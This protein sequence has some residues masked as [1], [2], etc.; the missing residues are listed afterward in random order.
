MERRDLLRALGSAT[1]L[2]FLPHKTLEAWTRVAS[3]ILPANGLDA[4]QMAL[5]RAVADTI[6]PRTE[7]PSA[8]DVGV[9]G[10]VNV[11]VAE[12]ATDE[13]RAEFL[14]GLA[15]ID[16]K[17][18]GSGGVV[19]ADLAPEARGAL[20]DSLET[21]NRDVE[22]SRTYWRLKGLIVH[23]YFT[24]EPVMKDVLK[25]TVMPGKFEGDAPLLM[26]SPRA[27]KQAPR[28]AAKQPEHDHA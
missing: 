25:H 6:L 19:F 18:K 4:A 26:I 24:S 28:P 23:G 21:G 9:H 5:V 16:E 3:G 20:L 1:A 10:F 8:T 27:P 12:Q 22:P 17:A 14:R 2:T 13:E 11:M 15:A 7:S